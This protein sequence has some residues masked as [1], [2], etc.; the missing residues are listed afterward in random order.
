MSSGVRVFNVGRRLWAIRLRR[1]WSLQTF[2]PRSHAT[3]LQNADPNALFRSTVGAATLVLRRAFIGVHS[4]PPCHRSGGGVREAAPVSARRWHGRRR[5]H[6]KP[7]RRYGG[8]P[9][10]CDRTRQ[11]GRHQG[12]DRRGGGA[13]VSI[14]QAH[15]PGWMRRQQRHSHVRHVVH[16]VPGAGRRHRHLRRQRVRRILSDRHA[17]VSGRVHRCGRPVWQRVSVR[18]A[19]LQWPVPI[20]DGRES[21]RNI[22]LAVS[23]SE[24]RDASHVR[25][26]Q[27]QLS[28]HDRDPSVRKQV[29][30]RW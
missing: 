20:R 9:R 23:S 8:G 3:V 17:A 7:A 30:H 26:D 4:V 12:P 6:R 11:L 16:G 19:R 29:R 14:R 10:P 5:G 24:R 27:L 25:R 15:V 21:V 2:A 18:A 22:V 28:V 1:D 13:A